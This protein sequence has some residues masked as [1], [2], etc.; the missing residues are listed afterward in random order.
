MKKRSKKMM[1]YLLVCCLLSGLLAGC[2]FLGNV[3]PKETSQD[4]MPD[5]E[6]DLI[7]VG[8]SQLGSESV[9]RTTNS[10]S[11][12][13]ELTKENGF[14][15]E[16]HNARQRQENQIKAIRG[17]ISQRV[18]Y[19][20]FSPVTEE[21]WDTVLQEAK[22]AGI[23]VILVDRKASLTDDS[24]YT[25]WVGSD[26]RLEGEKAGLWLEKYLEENGRGEDEI[27]IVVLR[28]TPGSSAQT[29]RTA[30]FNTVAGGHHN[31]HIL[32][33]ESADFT[34]AKGKEVME[35]FLDRYEDI[36]VVVSQNDDMTFGALQ[37]MEEHGISTGENCD[38]IVISFDAVPEALELVAQGKINLDVECNPRQGSYIAEIIKKLE[39]GESV[40]KETIVEE[41]IYTQD[42]VGEYLQIGVGENSVYSVTVTE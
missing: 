18:D 30:G 21:G 25:A 23:P 29:G 17:F 36:D 15:L 35:Q 26:M 34:T 5:E 41:D 8:F 24:L 3:T 27:N 39:A 42:N 38:I 16:F 4:A 32:A 6:E 9:W 2:G 37:A 19:I 28:G 14:F 13:G 20:L 33:Q 22:D 10:E 12:Q 11:I 7:V 1:G 31:W 40:E